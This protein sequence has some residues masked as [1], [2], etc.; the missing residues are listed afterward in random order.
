[1]TGDRIRLGVLGMLLLAAT[2]QAQAQAAAPRAAT[3]TGTDVQLRDGGGDLRL[4]GGRLS[5][6]LIGGNVLRV[7]FIPRTGATP[8]TL[9]MAPHSGGPSATSLVARRRG[10]DLL[11]RGG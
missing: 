9:V 10:R 2:W 7:H 8:P 5:L 4:A 6:R 1:M 3:G 11:L